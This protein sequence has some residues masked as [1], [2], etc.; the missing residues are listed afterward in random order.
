MLFSYKTESLEATCVSF[1]SERKTERKKERKE[2][3][4]KESLFLHSDV[5]H[6]V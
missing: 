1:D 2:K 6:T 3:I 4:K 5:N